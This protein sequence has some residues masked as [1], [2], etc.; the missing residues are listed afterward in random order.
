MKKLL[1]IIICSLLLVGCSSNTNQNIY[2]KIT[3]NNQESNSITTVYDLEF[4]NDVTLEVYDLKD[5]K[6]RLTDTVTLKADYSKLIVDFIEHKNDLNQ[7]EHYLQFYMFDGKGNELPEVYRY[8]YTN[9]DDLIIAS[10]KKDNLEFESE[11]ETALL[12]IKWGD[13]KL[14]PLEDIDLSA[15]CDAEYGYLVV[16][17]EKGNK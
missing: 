3:L 10:T 13:D 11:N 5:S 14:Y 1:S 8:L 16:V 9:E 2:N 15:P 17:H 7:R 4:K 12:I 6:W